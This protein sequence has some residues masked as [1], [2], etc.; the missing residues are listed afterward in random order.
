MCLIRY[1]YLSIDLSIYYSI[2]I[3]FLHLGDFFSD[4]KFTA[5]L[6]SNT[7]KEIQ[8]SDLKF[9][10]FNVLKSPGSLKTNIEL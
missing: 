3:I 4:W 8:Y 7:H 10:Y 2:I 6:N 9:V 5:R 1:L